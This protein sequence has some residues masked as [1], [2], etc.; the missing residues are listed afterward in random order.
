ME[1]L[2][3]FGIWF[4]LGGIISFVANMIGIAATRSEKEPQ[5]N[6]ASPLFIGISF[7]R[8]HLVMILVHFATGLK[9]PGILY[10][11]IACVDIVFGLLMMS[12]TGKRFGTE[13]PAARIKT[14]QTIGSIFFL[15]Y[16]GIRFYV[17]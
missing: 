2:I 17:L 14:G 16:Y 13:S 1:Y 3:A 6:G 12:A 5:F 9:Y 7:A 4:V 11:A 8:M 10:A 15:A